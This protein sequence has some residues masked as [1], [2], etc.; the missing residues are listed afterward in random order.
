M[1]TIYLLILAALVLI[2]F[3]VLLPGGILGV[4]AA[5]C[6]I[7]AT[8]FAAQD[9]G[10][11]VGAS[12]FIGSMLACLVLTVIEFKIFARTKYG[13]RFFLKDAVSGRANEK[14]VDDAIIGRTGETLTRL[15]PTGKIAIDGQTHEAH[16]QDGYIEAGVRVEVVARDNFKLTVKT[17]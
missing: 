17:L 1:S 15:N 10:I 13:R 2:F 8:V 11:Y 12:V 7:A 14:S 6:I 3:E 4:M 16:S 5:G 9:Y